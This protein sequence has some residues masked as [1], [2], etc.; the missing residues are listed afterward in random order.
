[1]S[2]NSSASRPSLSDATKEARSL[3]PTPLFKDID[4]SDPVEEL[5][6]FG[7]WWFNP[8][9]GQLVLSDTAAALLDV[10]REA[11]SLEECFANVL[12][13]DLAALVQ[14]LASNNKT[15]RLDEEFRLIAEHSGV[16]WLRLASLPLQHA[17]HGLHTGV[18]WSS[19]ATRNA[20]MRE[21]LGLEATRLLVGS[22]TLAEALTKIIQLVCENLGW[23]WG[24]YWS[25]DA[26]SAGGQPSLGCKYFWHVRDNRLTSFTE[27]S[28]SIR[29]PA[30]QGLIGQVWAAGLP[31]WVEDIGGDLCFLR[32]HSAERSGLR[33]GYALPVA[34]MAGDGSRHSP[35]VLEFFSSLPRQRDAQLP[36][37]S[38][39]IGGL[40]A[41]TVQRMEQQESIRK[42]ARLDEVTG[43]SNR[44]HF[45]EQLNE[46]CA[47]ST[48]SQHRFGVLYIDLD[49]FKRINDAFGR[50]SGNAVLR[51]V[52]QRL[53]QC[54]GS[55]FLVS[56]LGSDRFAILAN[57]LTSAD[58]LSKLAEKMIASLAEP[59]QLDGY[60]LT[61]TATAGTACFPEDG[62]TA[63]EIA[64]VADEGILRHSRDEHAE[65]RSA[66]PNGPQRALLVQQL[67]ME[68]ELRHALSTSQEFF[69]VYQPVF[70]P[71]DE[72][73]VAVEAL[74]RWAR[75]NGEV[76]SPE[77]FIPIAEQSRLI[78]KIGKWVV[79]QA[80]HDLGILHRAGFPDL[81][82][83]VNM[84]AQEFLSADMPRELQDITRDAGVAPR[85]LCLELTESTVMKHADR[86]VPIMLQLRDRGFKIALDDFGTGYSSLS[87]LKRLPISSIK[88]DRGF[89]TGL[90]HDRGDCAIVR[91][92]LDLGHHMKL[93]VIAEGVE[94]D[95]QLGFLRQFGCPLVQ[96]YR[97]SRPLRLQDLI[98]KF[99]AQH[100]EL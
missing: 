96:G 81:Q 79:R 36:Q 37:L 33:S 20:T 59:L 47:A 19:T 50:T 64:D 95:A 97:F 98:D 57:P 7:R 25:F 30:D 88:I 10:P 58:Q 80:C 62:L 24:A 75:P 42:L 14:K 48:A 85:H 74:I 56:R 61:L 93:P 17:A 69:L 4:L 45:F 90:P 34:Y 89:M 72:R 16:R 68:S 52:A 100:R 99:G 78:V 12:P 9:T 15:Q 71:F 63:S 86:V 5:A 39:T 87:R 3:S 73:M 32:R 83:N 22:N 55:D 65:Q 31:S 66:M 67:R 82:M 21:G 13:D 29:M 49:R 11:S 1:M 26:D 40:I 8:L 6:G 44:R 27:E 51:A 43:L 38:A 28:R 18:V 46:A 91:T 70:D 94:N 54:T 84:A 35:G 60:Q 76:I 2:D 92:I 77:I 53:K 23:E 41:Q